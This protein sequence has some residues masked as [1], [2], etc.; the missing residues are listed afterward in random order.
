MNVQLKIRNPKDAAGAAGAFF[1]LSS[2]LQLHWPWLSLRAWS[3]RFP[4]LLSRQLLT[5][6]L[7]T[8]YI[9]CLDPIIPLRP[10]TLSLPFSSVLRR[11]QPP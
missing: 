5:L 2:Y 9:M 6:C 1:S 11:V 10:P 3:C 7:S 4:C 8:K